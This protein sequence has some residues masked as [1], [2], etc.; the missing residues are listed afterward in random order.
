MRCFRI[1]NETD[2]L[3]HTF[4]FLGS[5]YL[6][7]AEARSKLEYVLD[8]IYTQSSDSLLHFAV[9]EWCLSMQLDRYALASGSPYLKDFLYRKLAS[10]PPTD[11]EGIVRNYKLIAE[12]AERSGD[13]FTAAQALYKL[14][15]HETAQIPISERVDFLA[16]IGFLCQTLGLR[17]SAPEVAE[18]LNLARTHYMVSQIG[19]RHW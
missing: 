3:D 8:W 13:K 12:C 15:V 5:Q 16:R 19:L 18:F 10:L 9:F 7:P 1:A 14:A 11:L 6:K 4:L 2:G 17:G